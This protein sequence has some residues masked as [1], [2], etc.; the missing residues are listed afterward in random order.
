LISQALVESLVLS[1][2]GTVAGV[3]LATLLIRALPIVLPAQLSVVGIDEIDVNWHVLAFAAGLS[4]V[5]G[6]LFGLLPALHASA[7]DLRASLAQ[8]GRGAAGVRRRARLALVIGEVALAALAL[9][10]AGLVLRSFAATMA[11]P[12]GF[13]PGGRLTFMLSIP[14]ARYPTPDAR[15]QALVDL[16]ERFKVLPG[17]ATVGAVNLLPLDGGDSRTG[18]GI[19]GREPR[20]DEPPTRMHPRIVTPGY[21]QAMDIQIVRGRGFTL[22]DTPTSEPVVMIN[23][24]AAKRFWG[25][26]NPIGARLHFGGDDTWRTVVG[27]TADVRHWGLR[28][29]VNPM[30]YWPQ[31][32]ANSQFLTFVLKTNLEPL[33]MAPAV[34]AAVAAFDANLPIARMRTLDDV[35]ATSVRSER[36]QTFLMGAFGLVALALAMIGI[37]GVMAQLVTARRQEIG[38]RM[39]LGARPANILRQ[40]LTEGFWQAAAGLVIGLVAGTALMRLAT[41][42]LFNVTPTDPLTLGA[43]GVVLMSAALLAC[44]IPGRRAMRT[45]PAGALKNQ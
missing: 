36:S 37:Y 38:V 33:S 28:L 12:L 27:V 45:D 2:V 34:R 17:V 14:A 16:E 6:L 15:R 18:I 7:P 23:Q 25:D 24:T 31:T 41:T 32:Q 13:E 22:E 20:P 42:L 30:L 21:F 5:T 4:L 10:G 40:L 19:E 43:V 44:V 8:G 29:D 11:Q 3:G 9:V 26:A 1:G 39:A 35:V